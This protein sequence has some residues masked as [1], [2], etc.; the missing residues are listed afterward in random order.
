[1]ASF[2]QYDKQA[3]AQPREERGVMPEGDYVAQ[4]TDSDVRQNKKRNGT[5]LELERVIIS[6]A[7]FKG[8]K[9]WQYINVEH[10]TS[11]AQEIGQRELANLKAAVGI[12]GVVA[13]TL[14][15]HNRPHG[16]KL[17]IEKGNDKPEGGQYPDKNIVFDCFPLAAGAQPAAAPAAAPAPAAA[18]PAPAAAPSAAAANTPPWLKRA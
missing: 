3:A 6:P 18:S 16:I 2:A 12:H 11:E 1:M 13:D 4:I 7:E 14:M 17:K 10:E 8:R 5:V 9:V 15:M